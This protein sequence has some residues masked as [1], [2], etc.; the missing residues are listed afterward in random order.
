MT[1]LVAP[2]ACLPL[3]PDKNNIWDYN[4][5]NTVG[6][7]IGLTRATGV[8]KGSFKGWFDYGKTHTSRNI[9]FE[10]VL[11]PEREDKSDGIEGRGFFLWPDKALQPN[12]KGKPVS[13]PFNWSYDFLIQSGE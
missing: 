9:P 7:T 2:K 4:A 1:G 12:P 8:F 10:G 3:D 11:T 5:E 13:Y 6:L